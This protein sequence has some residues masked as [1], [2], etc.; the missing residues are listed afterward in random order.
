MIVFLVGLAVMAPVVILFVNPGD[1]FRPVMRI[2]Y[3]FVVVPRLAA[4]AAFVGGAL[5]WGAVLVA[6]DRFPAGRWPR[7]LWVPTV[8]FVLV[9]VLATLFAE[10]WRYSLL[11]EFQRYQGLAATLLYVLLFAVATVA[12]RSM[13]DLRL[14]LWGV[15]A[16]AMVATVYALIQKAGLDWI[17]WT[18]RAVNLPFSTMGQANNFGAYLVAAVAACAFLALTA[19][20]AEP[21]FQLAL[22]LT[23]AGALALGYVLLVVLLDG[24][25][26]IVAGVVGGALLVGLTAGLLRVWLQPDLRE[27]VLPPA[28][29]IAMGAAIVAMLFALF[30]TVSRSAYIGI[31]AV[32]LLWG[33]AVARWFIPSF[34]QDEQRRR[35]LQFGAVALTVAPVVVALFAVLFIGLPQGKIAVYSGSNDEAVAGRRTLWLMATEM[36]RDRPLLG[37]GQDAFAIKFQDYRDAPDLP[38]IGFGSVAPESSHNF[39]LDLSSGTGVLG[40]LSF[41]GLVGSVLGLAVWHAEKTNDVSRRLAVTALGSAVVGYVVAIFFGFAEAMTTWVFWL[42]LGALAGLLLERPAAR[43]KDNPGRVE[44]AEESRPVTRRE[45]REQARRAEKQARRVV[46]EANVLTAGLAAVALS[47]VGATALAWSA[48]LVAADLAAGQANAALARNEP[49]AAVRLASRAATL[50]PVNRDYLLQEAEA[51]QRASFGS[52]EA[53]ATLN[54]SIASY[55]TLIERFKPEA[56]ELLGLANAHLMLAEAEGTPVEAVTPMVSDLLERTLRAAR[57]NGEI[58]LAVA[59]VYEQRLNDADRAYEIRVEVYCWGVDVC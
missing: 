41:L 27:R 5:L 55:D 51:R 54:G 29:E 13:R 19:R 12:V 9:N 38:G 42:L 2:M 56:T 32:V 43:E 11:G 7:L 22:L 37:H 10:S 30:F 18:G 46:M 48:T 39:L 21:R 45:R 28:V 57:F 24:P 23:A 40:L 58:Y 31:G 15:L 53:A 6:R 16:G 3:D 50:N 47:L 20:R 44:W 33:V 36:T 25:P 8:L 17:G 49:D 35:T 14:L 52:S 4:T 59:D 34:V 1:D 26:R